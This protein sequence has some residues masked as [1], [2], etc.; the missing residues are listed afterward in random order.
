MNTYY[1]TYAKGTKLEG[2]YSKVVAKTVQDA[3]KDVQYFIGRCFDN[4]WTQKGFGDKI[5]I[6][7]EVPL[8]EQGG[9]IS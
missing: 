8:Q 3:Y 9:L 2:Y 5:N 1:I 7:S 4:L 6:L